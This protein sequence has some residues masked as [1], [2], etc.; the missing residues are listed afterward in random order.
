MPIA[1]PR[2]TINRSIII[3]HHQQ[4]FLDWLQSADP[5]PLPDITLADLANDGDAFMIP[6]GDV[7]DGVEDA[8]KWV[9]KRWRMFF[10][11]TLGEWLTDE[12]LW[13]QKLTLKM[14]REWFY[15]EYRSMVWDLVDAPILIED[16]EDEPDTDREDE[17]LH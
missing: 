2:Y 8:E 9:E 4:P 10:E 6:D 16:W 3:L 11:Y 14:F 15:I 13:P 17:R 12:S 7:V 1:A 5:S